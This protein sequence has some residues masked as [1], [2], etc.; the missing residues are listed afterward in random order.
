MQ[1]AGRFL[2]FKE[3]VEIERGV[4][5]SVLNAES[6][7]RIVEARSGGETTICGSL[8]GTQQI[9]HGGAQFLTDS[10]EV[11]RNAG[12]VFTD[13]TT[14]FGE[15][16]VFGV[17]KLEASTVARFKSRKSGGER[18]AELIQI[19]F[20]AGVDGEFDRAGFGRAARLAVGGGIVEGS[21]FFAGA[22]GVNMALGQHGAQPSFERTAPVKIAEE[23][24]SGGG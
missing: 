22:D 4:F 12:F 14:D 6:D 18:L 3:F 1:S 10:F 9:F 23:G 17:V 8:P 7:L 11:A 5:R 20:A 24:T 15:G 19:L 2:R 21:K 16:A 13:G